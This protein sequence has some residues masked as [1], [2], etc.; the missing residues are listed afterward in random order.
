MGDKG[1]DTVTTPEQIAASIEDVK[2]LLDGNR[3]LSIA[4]LSRRIRDLEDEMRKRFR[5]IKCPCDALKALEDSV[6]KL[7][8][9]LEQAAVKFREMREELDKYREK[10]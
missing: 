8:K 1:M 10:S 7:E 3:S 9:R 6:S 2:A 4:F 5:E